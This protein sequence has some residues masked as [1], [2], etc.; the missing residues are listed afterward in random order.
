MRDFVYYILGA[1]FIVKNAR[2]KEEASAAYKFF[3]E[4]DP[5]YNKEMKR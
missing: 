4:G 5:K 1:L 2:T 3:T